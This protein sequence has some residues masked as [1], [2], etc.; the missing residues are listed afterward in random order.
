MYM[1]IYIYMYIYMYNHFHGVYKNPE[2][3]G[4]TRN[5]ETASNQTWRCPSQQKKG[6]SEGKLIEKW[7]ISNAAM[8]AGGYDG[9]WLVVEPYPSEKW[10]SESQLGWSIC[11]YMEKNDVWNHK[12]EYNPQMVGLFVGSP[13][14][15]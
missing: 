2:I 1:Y 3:A 8:S 14:W 15:Y 12:P 10:W 5:L 11:E 13:M 7:E 4:K 9:I 6:L